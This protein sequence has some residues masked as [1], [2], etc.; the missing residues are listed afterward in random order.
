MAPRV[1]YKNTR[2]VVGRLKVNGGKRTKR[3]YTGWGTRIL[4]TGFDT[5]VRREENMLGKV[6]GICA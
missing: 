5:S 3:E 1:N 6:T 2:R 4:N